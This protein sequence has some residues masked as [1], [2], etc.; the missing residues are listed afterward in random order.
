MVGMTGL[1]LAR[2][3]DRLRVRHASCYD[4][5]VCLR[6]SIRLSYLVGLCACFAL[7][8]SCGRIGFE[9]V[10][11]EVQ[12]VDSGAL[13]A[14]PPV[15]ADP[16]VIADAAVIDATPID[17]ANSCNA[18]VV[19]CPSESFSIEGG[20]LAERSGQLKNQANS[21]E[22]PDGPCSFAAGTVDYSYE[23]D[24]LV[25][26]SVSITSPSRTRWYLL[27]GVCSG[28]MVMCSA[29]GGMDTQTL[30][31]G[32]YTLVVENIGAIGVCESFDITFLPPPS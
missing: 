5:S 6:P 2:S 8:S 30:A 15:D 13:D 4:G 18:K 25:A 14:K 7:S 17:A 20:A 22:P 31:A 9:S 24:L 16:E 23:I 10:A 19:G 29:I 1:T 3:E 11:S 26:G 12:E 27:K 28:E 32:V 21:L